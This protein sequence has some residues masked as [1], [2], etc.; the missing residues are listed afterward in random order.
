MSRIRFAQGWGII[1]K[2]A[3]EQRYGRT[4]EELQV[5][6]RQMSGKGSLEG[7]IYWCIAKRNFWTT[8]IS[9]GPL[10]FHYTMFPPSSE[11]PLFIHKRM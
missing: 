5:Q 9:S 2:I 7:L 11:R 1:D 6:Q 4:M 10:T 8:I 3:K